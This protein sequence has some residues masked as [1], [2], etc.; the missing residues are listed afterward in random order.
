MRCL[1]DD[2]FSRFEHR[3]V[4]RRTDGNQ[5]TAYTAIAQ[6]RVKRA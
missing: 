1:R 5:F 2:S 6:K 4:H 3:L